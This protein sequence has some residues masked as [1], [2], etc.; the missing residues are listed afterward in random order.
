MK[1]I[2]AQQNQAS[3]RRCSTWGHS[4]NGESKD[5]IYT[6]HIIVGET[7]RLKVLD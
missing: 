1:M 4:V 7:E 2:R 3:N 5:L 6:K